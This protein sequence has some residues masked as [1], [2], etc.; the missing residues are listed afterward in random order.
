MG[1]LY[2]YVKSRRRNKICTNGYIQESFK[3]ENW[4]IVIS[5]IAV[6]VKCRKPL[7]KPARQQAHN[8]WIKDVH[9][10]MYLK[11]IG[12]R[13][14]AKRKHNSQRDKSHPDLKAD[15][16]FTELHTKITQFTERILNAKSNQSI[17]S[18]KM[19]KN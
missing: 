10:Y 6:I 18:L 13:T 12:Q 17:I 5:S 11:F 19:Q 9:V 16:L 14:K 3:W 8:P 1:F 15:K 4:G 2:T 7:I